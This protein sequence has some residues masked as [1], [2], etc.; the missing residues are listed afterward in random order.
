MSQNNYDCLDLALCT[1][2]GVGK[3]E[4]KTGAITVTPSAFADMVDGSQS[5]WLRYSHFM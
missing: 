1:T 4:S 3:C 5:M 2:V